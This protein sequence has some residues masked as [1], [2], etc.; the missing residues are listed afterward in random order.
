MNI[1]HGNSEILY[2]WQKCRSWQRKW[3]YM[4][5]LDYQLICISHHVLFQSTINSFDLSCIVTVLY[6]LRISK[7]C[8][9]CRDKHFRHLRMANGGGGKLPSAYLG[10]YMIPR[11]KIPMATP[12]FTRARNLVKLS[13]ICVIQVEV[14]NPRWR[15][16]NR[17]Y[18]YLNLHTK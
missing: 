10:F 1:A 7:C 11:N 2:A 9:L 4:C 6:T 5:R 3:K 15:L 17:K 14:R 8:N 12:I 13:S 16:T 18:L